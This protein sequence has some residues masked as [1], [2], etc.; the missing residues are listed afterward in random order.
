MTKY[1]NDYDTLTPFF[2][3]LFFL[4]VFNCLNFWISV[5]A[6][7]EELR[8]SEQ[9]AKI[10]N[11]AGTVPYPEFM[12]VADNNITE[13]KLTNRRKEWYESVNTYYLP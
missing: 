8:N 13:L 12:K 6:W 11:I 5:H 7:Q 4:I 2:V 10:L 1:T 9:L 3:A